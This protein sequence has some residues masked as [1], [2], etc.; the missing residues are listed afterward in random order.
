MN[1]EDLIQIALENGA[2]KAT[3]IPQEKIVLSSVFR[4]ICEKNSCGAFG[5]C[6]M[7]P[8]D[9]GEIDELMAKVRS[10][11]HGLLYQTI[12]QIE[13]SFDIEG[14]GEGGRHHAMV[15][16]EIQ[17]AML[18][19]LGADILHLTC[20]GC[21][22]CEVC[23]KRDDLPC[24]HPEA[25]LPSLES[26]GIDVYNTTKDTPLKYINGTNTVT[27]FGMVLFTEEKDA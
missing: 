17:K 8:P 5:K 2:A 1:H 7:C 12:T 11:S 27:F 10:Y 9:V 16:Q 18:P 13:D 19:L 4:E 15:S 23:A 25:A 14:M 6:W 3:V 26:Y 20:G 24:R 21:R 22:L